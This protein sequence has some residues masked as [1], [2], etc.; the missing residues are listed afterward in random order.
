VAACAAAGDP[1][2]APSPSPGG[3]PGASPSPSPSPAALLTAAQL[4]LGLL[5]AFGSL[6][7]CDP[8]EYPVGRGDE[9]TLAAERMPEIRAD[10]E[11]WTAITTA[12][13][14]D[15][16]AASLSSDQEVAIY[17]QWKVLSAIEL[18]PADGRFAFDEL[19][20]PKDAAGQTGEHVTG[21]IGRDGTIAVG[22]RAVAGEPMCPICL[23][24]G[25]GILGPAVAVAV[26]D[27]RV[28][29]TVWTLDAV[30]RRVVGTVLAVASTPVPVS[31]RVVRLVLSDGRTLSASPGHPLADGRPLGDLRRGDLVDGA[32]VT[33]AELVAYRGGR[34]FDLV[35][36]GPTGLYLAGSGIPLASTIDR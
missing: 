12:L 1:S 2:V 17:R 11:A 6:W 18:T 25:T 30:G 26:E 10:A 22:Q 34:T 14:F 16:G 7:Y 5:G 29:D 13:G 24:R 4:K 15:P 23:A 20:G 31:H 32:R 33:V 35:V 19:F 36:S 27:L 8:D 9:A 28:G 3:S 21:T